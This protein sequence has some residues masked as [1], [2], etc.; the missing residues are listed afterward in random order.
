MLCLWF[1]DKHQNDA[2]TRHGKALD[3]L[4]KVMALRPGAW[5]ACTRQEWTGPT[6]S[7]SFQKVCPTVSSYIM[8]HPTMS[9][10]VIQCHTYVILCL[11]LLSYLSREITV[12]MQRLSSASLF[13]DVLYISLLSSIFGERKRRILRCHAEL[14][15]FLWKL[16]SRCK[17]MQA[18]QAQ[19]AGESWDQ[20]L[21]LV[22]W[23]PPGIPAYSSIFIAYS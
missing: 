1:C 3:L 19:P 14:F 18:V 23:I 9:Y 11:A 2:L 16:W 20:V 7:H 21:R 10:N 4:E 13:A 8:L 5:C 22:L 17:S 12:H 15:L 6:E